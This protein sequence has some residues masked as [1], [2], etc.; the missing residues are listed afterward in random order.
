MSN[1]TLK[2]IKTAWRKKNALFYGLLVPLSGLFWLLTSIRRLVYSAQILK[3]Y[4]LSVPVIVV[5]NINVG[6]S[7]KTPVV[8]WLVE[9]LKSQGYK[10]AVISRGYGGTINSSTING[11]TGKPPINV[12][13]TSDPII[14][15]DE[16]VLVASRC[17]CPVMVGADRVHVGLELLKAYPECNVIISDDGLQHY[18]LK[19]D[20]EIAVV[21]GQYLHHAR[22]IP[23]GQL[24]EP[25]SRLNTVDAIIKN[26]VLNKHAENVDELDALPKSFSMQL[27]G[28][29][30]Y[31]LANPTIKANA[32]DFKRKSIQAIAGIGNPKRFFEHLQQLGMTFS[33]S[34]FEDHHAYTQQ[35][36]AKFDGD[37]LIMTEKDA[38][39]CKPYAMA[40]HWVL[41]V[42]AQIDGALMPLILKKIS[43]F[44]ANIKE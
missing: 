34:S 31:N 2:K 18:R 7:G 29:Q 6:G 39:K 19:R 43:Q 17:N 13:S 4:A 25:L 8:I 14:V 36:L 10:P 24:R 11:G 9:Q 21:D 1:F 28:D 32:Q 23:A 30:F 37:V 27:V 40:H 22:L 44:K 41:P 33:G 35:E 26:T 16:P 3:S 15:G 20:V 5:G 42:E 38:V 12:T